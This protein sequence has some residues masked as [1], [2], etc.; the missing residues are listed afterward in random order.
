MR[1][2]GFALAIT[3]LVIAGAIDAGIRLTLTTRPR[4]EGL[5]ARR[6]R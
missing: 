3:A 2:A 6:A 1:N 4:L 5:L